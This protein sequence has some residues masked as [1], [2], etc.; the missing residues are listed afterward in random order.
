MECDYFYKNFVIAFD[1]A[2]VINGHV[3]GYVI[4]KYMN[5]WNFGVLIKKDFCRAVYVLKEMWESERMLELGAVYYVFQ[6]PNC[7]ET[8]LLR[9]ITFKSYSNRM[10]TS[11]VVYINQQCSI[12]HLVRSVF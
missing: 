8:V 9:S 3:L 5:F 2:E 7:P 12:R 6:A 10:M 4:R 1:V 11:I